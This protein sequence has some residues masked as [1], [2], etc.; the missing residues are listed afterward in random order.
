MI[1]KALLS[2]LLAG[3][4]LSC[5][6]NVI[7]ETIDV[8]ETIVETIPGTSDGTIRIALNGSSNLKDYIK[9]SYAMVGL[10]ETIEKGTFNNIPTGRSF[11]LMEG[12][13]KFAVFA[14]KVKD[15]PADMFS[16]KEGF[17]LVLSASVATPDEGKVWYFCNLNNAIISN[18]KELLEKTVNVI[19]SGINEESPGTGKSRYLMFTISANDEGGLGIST[20]FVASKLID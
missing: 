14:E 4:F 2:I 10:D 5:Q 9:V 20:S 3:L 15:I 11:E 8:P 18:E 13:A 1:K 17:T 6:R 7:P 16:G 12:T 19:N